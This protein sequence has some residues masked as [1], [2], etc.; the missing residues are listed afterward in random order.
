MSTEERMNGPPKPLCHAL[1]I[2]QTQELHITVSAVQ[3]IQVPAITLK[4]TEK[5][6]WLPP[7]YCWLINEA[8]KLAVEKIHLV[9]KVKL[10]E[11][12]VLLT[13]EVPDT[14]L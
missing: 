11:I 6:E 3:Q 2:R 7:E 8:S 4:L 1:T 9:G 14:E 13:A 12:L 5:I 10:S